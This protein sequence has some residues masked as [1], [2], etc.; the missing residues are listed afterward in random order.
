MDSFTFGNLLDSICNK[1]KKIIEKINNYQEYSAKMGLN[2]NYIIETNSIINNCCAAKSVH[3]KKQEVANL[4]NYIKIKSGLKI[5]LIIDNID[6][7]FHK[8]KFSSRCMAKLTD[9]PMN[10]VRSTIFGF[11]KDNGSPLGDVG[12]NLL[13][14]LRTDSYDMLKSIVDQEGTKHHAIDWFSDD[15]NTFLLSNADWKDV[16][17]ER[18]QLLKKIIKHNNK[19]TYEVKYISQ[20]IID[21]LIE[22][23][24]LTTAIAENVLQMSRYR[25]RDIISFF[26]L[27]SWISVKKDPLNYTSA[28]QSANPR[29]SKQ[30]PVANIAFM[31][32]GK[33]L[34]SENCSKYPNIYN[35][36][37]LHNK[38]KH[39]FW[40]PRLILEVIYNRDKKG[41]AI[42]AQ[43][44]IDIFSH[45]KGYNK[46]QVWAIIEKLSSVQDSNLIKMKIIYDK[47]K[48]IHARDL[49]L[50][51]R[52]RHFIENVVDKFAYLQLV[53]DDFELYIP[54]KLPQTNKDIPYSEKFLYV[55]YSND[56]S[57]IA[58]NEPLYHEAAKEMIAEKT[59]TTMF[60]VQI[61]IQSL[62]VYESSIFYDSI[63]YVKGILNNDPTN[64]VF[65]PEQ[66]ARS[67]MSEIEILSNSL[68]IGGKINSLSNESNLASS[69]YQVFY[70]QFIYTARRAS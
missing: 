41:L 36:S 58:L 20:P 26:E 10:E 21:S 54:T 15:R 29:L 17:K 8:H 40:L 37:D 42:T 34:Y 39:S 23:D 18:L 63:K 62:Q 16:V 19:I 43:E 46:E 12:L 67:V 1:T 6:Q 64:I 9:N 65:H 68:G 22:N 57:Y 30:Y 24:E 32:G 55:N 59:Y 66:I 70:E 69:A 51:M 7:I 2:Q 13:F 14:V 56:Y 61:L 38:Y 11:H 44:V 47:K 4:L 48:Y 52:G 50:T 53:V 27:Y 60:F 49:S 3:V 5:L 33:R 31:L 45:G 28:S 35:V 25:M